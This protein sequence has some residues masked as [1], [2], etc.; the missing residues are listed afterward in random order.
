[1]IRHSREDF[2]VWFQIFAQRHD[3]SD[4]P[5]TVAVV[6][7]R[8]NGHDVLRGKMILIPFVDELMCSSDE[9]EIVD[10]VELP[11]VLAQHPLS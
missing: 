10:V 7:S 9:L 6:R 2:E 1:M 4:I 5:A 3:R 8:P 11:I